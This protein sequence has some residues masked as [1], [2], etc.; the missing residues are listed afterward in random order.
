[1]SFDWLAIAKRLEAIAQTGLYYS[2]DDYDKERYEEIRIISHQILNE[3]TDTPLIKIREIFSKETGYPTPKVD[4]RAVIFRRDKILMVREKSDGQWSLPGGWA[5]IGLTPSEVAVKEVEEETGLIVTAERV[6]AILDK[7]CHQHPPSLLHVYKIFIL[8]NEA[9][10]SLAS[11]IE[12][13]EVNFFELSG[14]PPLSA[15]R[16]TLEQVRMVFD[17]YKKGNINILFD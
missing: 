12:T 13:T 7:K 9:G 5:D 8:C 17:Q 6:L 1:M 10:G 2:N 15:E 16:I 4:I 11:G 14:L 3:Y